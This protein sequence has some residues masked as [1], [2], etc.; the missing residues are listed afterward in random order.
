M[1]LVSAIITTHNRSPETV[2]RAV[3]SVL[4]QTYENMELIVVDDSTSE[5]PHREDVEDTV[6]GASDK[7]LYINSGLSLINAKNEL[8]FLFIILF[9]YP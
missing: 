6:R 9:I 5:Y 4:S 8:R 2:L 3:N 1:E 7:I